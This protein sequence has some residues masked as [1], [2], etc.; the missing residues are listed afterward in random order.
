MNRS[1]QFVRKI[2]SKTEH[3]EEETLLSN[4]S[5]TIPSQLL[6]IFCFGSSLFRAGAVLPICSGNWVIQYQQEG[7]AEIRSS[8]GNFRVRPGD[9]LIVP[10]RVAYT[11][12]VPLRQDMRKCYL[13]LR[14]GPLPEILLGREIRCCGMKIATAGDDSF[15]RLF[16][17]IGKTFADPDADSQKQLSVLLYELVAGIQNIIAGNTGNSFYCKLREAAA[18]LQGKKITLEDLTEIFSMGKH[19]LIREFRKKTGSSPVAYM[20]RLRLQYAG[21]LLL[22]S[23]MSIREIADTCGYS[24]A[25]FFSSDFKK[26]TGFT[27]GEYRVSGKNSLAGIPDF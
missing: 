15:G 24:S 10:P 16:A 20:I 22:L 4:L 1:F 23:D 12:R 27:P 5:A 25:S 21:Q 6:D 17:A 11:Y 8:E 7:E 9:L 19:T 2:A 26:H 3:Y 14:S 18:R 13:M